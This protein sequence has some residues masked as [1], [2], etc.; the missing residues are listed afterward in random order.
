M[1]GTSIFCFLDIKVAWHHKRI[2]Y[3]MFKYIYDFEYLFLH[4]IWKKHMNQNIRMYQ[5]NVWGC[6]MCL[7]WS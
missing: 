1:D 2:A 4:L 5:T 3:Y 7:N 6:G